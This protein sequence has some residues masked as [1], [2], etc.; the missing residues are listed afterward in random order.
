MR[1]LRETSL[2]IMSPFSQYQYHKKS[3]ITVLSRGVPSQTQS[4]YEKM[5]GQSQA[6]R[7]DTG[8]WYGHRLTCGGLNA[9]HLTGHP[10][11]K[12]HTPPQ[13]RRRHAA[14]EYS[15]LD[16]NFSMRQGI[17]KAADPI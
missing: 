14:R 5:R 9:Q 8:T 2:I 12:K 11:H 16:Y 10:R 4:K 13:Q 6:G 1:G 17:S 7:Q 3:T 15:Q